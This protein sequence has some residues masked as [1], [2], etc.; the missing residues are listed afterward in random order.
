[1]TTTLPDGST[2]TGPMS[3]LQS[4]VGITPK[5]GILAGE[6]AEYKYTPGTSGNIQMTIENPGAN[7]LGR[8]SWRQVR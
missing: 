8:Q 5:P 1:M 3:G 4:E 7:A 2:Y 6:T